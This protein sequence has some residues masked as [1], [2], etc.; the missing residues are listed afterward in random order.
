VIGGG[1]TLPLGR[2]LALTARAN[3]RSTDD[4][5]VGGRGTLGNTDASNTGGSLGLGYVGE[6]A[7]VGIAFRASS[8]EYGVPFPT[9]GEPI[10]L[11]GSRTQGSLRAT[12]NTG[13]SRVPTLRIDGTVQRYGHDELEP[14]GA[15]GTNFLL[16]T[17]TF[18]VAA[19]TQGKRLTGTIGVQGLFRDYR[20]TGDEAFTPGATNRNVGL[21]LF[22]ELPLQRAARADARVARLQLGARYDWFTLTSKD[23]A[24]GRFGPAQQRTFNSTSASLGLSLPIGRAAS[25]SL[26]AQRAFRAPTVEEVFADG[27]HAAVGTYDVGNR[28]LAAEK[29]TG[30]EGIVRTQ[31]TRGFAQLSAYLN[32]V[33]D[34]VAPVAIG[35]REVEGEDGPVEVPLVNFRQQDARLYG[36]EAQGEREVARHWVLGASADWVRGRFRD[37]TNLPYIPAGRVAAT[38]RWDNGRFSLGGG[39]RQVFKQTKVSG[40]ALDLPTD[41]YT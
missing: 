2:R 8:F 39:V 33:G 21:L 22:Q 15:V 24:S 10:R 7:Q 1:A 13:A 38:L 29:S 30:L 41:S 17:Q 14:S 18:N 20:P 37:E 16:N 19:R 6:R 36:V 12:I 26:N 25:F 9:D 4:L 40:D 28:S 27:Y 3:W 23:D 32:Q 31:S 11:D 34:Y 35:T 5:R